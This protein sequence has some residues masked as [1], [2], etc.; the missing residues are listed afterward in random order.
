MPQPSATAP[1][2]LHPVGVVRS[3]NKTPMLTATDEGLTLTERLDKIRRS[4]RKMRSAEA[5]LVIDPKIGEEILQGV[6]G[7]SHILVIYWPHLLPQERR[8]LRRVHPMGRSD[9]PAQGIF[10]TCSPARP[11]PI[12]VSAVRLLERRENVLRVQG[13]DAVDGSPVLDIKP[14]VHYSMAVEDAKV[15]EWMDRIHRELGED[16]TSKQSTQR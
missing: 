4:V 13:L 11:N 9:L 5:Q 6:E 8:N 7:F 2:V 1:L 16:D 14:Y 3:A 10:A 15:P 12:L